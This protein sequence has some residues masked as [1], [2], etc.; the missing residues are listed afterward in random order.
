MA[1]QDLAKV[2]RFRQFSVDWMV[3]ERPTCH[4]RQQQ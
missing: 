4:S 2:E 3:G 1:A